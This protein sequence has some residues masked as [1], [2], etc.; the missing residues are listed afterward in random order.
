[1]SL[2]IIQASTPEEAVKEVRTYKENGFVQIKIYSSVKAEVVKAICAEAH[3]LGLTVTGHIPNGMTLMQGI[4]AGM[5][6][7]NHEQYV[8][9]VLKKNKDRTIDLDDPENVKIF[10][11][12]LSHHVV[13]D[14]TLSVFEWVFR[15]VADPVTEIEP[16]F[17]EVPKPL[18]ALFVNTGMPAAQ[19]TAYRQLMTNFE[20]QVSFMFRKGI[21][22]VAGTDM[23]IPGYSLYREMEL[24]VKAGLKPFEALQTATLIP[25]RVMKRDGFSGSVAVGKDA[26]LI[27]VEGDPL[28]RIQD[29]RKLQTVI[30]GGRIYDPKALHLMVGFK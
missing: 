5:D 4:E 1:M 14:P 17:N 8:N 19:A 6:M 16:A 28:T 12:I 27:I 9:A 2:G 29:I 13:I 22:I 3:R 23:G 24:Y 18:Q 30:K 7:V 11:L 15:S 26:D 20:Q 25:A 21:P 10:D